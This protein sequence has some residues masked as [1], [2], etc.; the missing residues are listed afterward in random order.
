M[1]LPGGKIIVFTGLLN[2]LRSKDELSAVLA[3]ETGHVVARHVVSNHI[4]I[5]TI[6]L[7]INY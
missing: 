6:F 4:I 2:L 5:V 7:L 3:H 1:C